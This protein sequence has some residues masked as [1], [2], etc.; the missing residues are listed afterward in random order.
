LEARIA[1][2]DAKGVGELQVRG[3]QVFLGYW[4]RPEATEEAFA[5]DWLRTGDLASMDEAGFITIRGR[6]K[7]L[8]VNREGKNIYPEEVEQ[9]IAHHPLVGDVVVLAYHGKDEPGERVGAIVSPNAD[10]VARVYP[11]HTPEQVTALLREAVK[12]QCESLAAYKLPRKV[13]VSLTPLERTSTQKVR[14]GFYAGSLD[15]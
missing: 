3:P 12:H 2:P 15:E 1:T 13:V 6:A 9:A 10:Y 4:K 14:R 7:A 5:G 11:E 8:I